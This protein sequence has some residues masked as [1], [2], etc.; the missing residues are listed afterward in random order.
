[1]ATKICITVD[2]LD[3]DTVQVV[4]GKVVAKQTEDTNT[5]Q[6]TGNGITVDT[7]QI[8]ELVFREIDQ[9][10]NSSN[11]LMLCTGLKVGDE[12]YGD[13]PD[14]GSYLNPFTNETIEDNTPVEVHQ[15]QFLYKENPNGN[16]IEL[17]GVPDNYVPQLKVYL[18]GDKVGT[19]TKL[20][21]VE[22]REVLLNGRPA[23]NYKYNLG[24]VSVRNQ[25]K[26]TL[27]WDFDGQSFSTTELPRL[28]PT[29]EPLGIFGYVG[30]TQSD[31]IKQ[32]PIDIDIEE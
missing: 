25:D 23:K 7:S 13:R 26:E 11:K 22:I 30:N 17:V 31:V 18:Y 10:K 24:E 4:E 16:T 1:M 21:P 8:S 12:W 3:K 20:D 28:N 14:R 27:Q 6:F 15:A 2:N 32:M 5:I 29:N 19:G 9:N